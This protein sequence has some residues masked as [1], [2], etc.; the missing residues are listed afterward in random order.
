MEREQEKRTEQADCY[1][2]LYARSWSLITFIDIEIYQALTKALHE[3]THVILTAAPHG[4]IPLIIRSWGL[5]LSPAGWW[6]RIQILG[7]DCWTWASTW[8]Y[9]RWMQVQKLPED[10]TFLP[11][12]CCFNNCQSSSTWGRMSRGWSWTLRGGTERGGDWVT[13]N[14]CPGP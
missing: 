8:C 13:W 6:C 14:P 4:V 7:A 10:V 12:G 11:F 3:L 2:L 9:S 5:R 1:V